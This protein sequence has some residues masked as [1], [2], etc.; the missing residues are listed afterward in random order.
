MKSIISQCCASDD[1]FLPDSC[2]R[3]KRA[4]AVNATAADDLCW[5]PPT[6]CDAQVRAAEHLKLHACRCKTH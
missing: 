3:L 1:D 5:Q 4:T 6:L 2:T